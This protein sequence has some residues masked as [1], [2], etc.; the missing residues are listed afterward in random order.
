M[1]F[2]DQGKISEVIPV[3]RN[4]AHR[5]IEECMLAANVCA[6]DF[7]AAHQHATLYR[8]HP[9]PTPEKLEVVRQ[10][11]GEVGLH[12]GG[13]DEPKARDYADVITKIQ[14][15]PDRDLL[16]TVLLRSL[17]QARYSPE[18]L[19]HFGLAYEAYAHFTSPIRRYPDLLVHRAIRAVLAGK[20]YTPG[21]ETGSWADIGNHCSATER[22]ADEATRD[23]EQW[24]KAWFMQD[25]INEEYEGTVSS[26]THFGLFVS[27]DHIHVE[28]LVHISE[29]GK[30]YFHHD[31]VRHQLLGERSGQRW[32]LG[33]RIWIKVVRVDLETTKIDFSPIEAPS[34]VRSSSDSDKIKKPR[35]RRAPAKKKEATLG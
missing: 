30:D 1:L 10:F 22:R 31:P 18:N 16:Q 35:A 3:V 7:L 15:R 34:K 23:V 27:L 13:G 2:D 33:D 5:I 14:D 28:G 32:R 11:L 20:N 4:D 17:Q 6:S 21:A 26:V 9:G 12:L 8:I 24:L 29:L 25:H 19:G